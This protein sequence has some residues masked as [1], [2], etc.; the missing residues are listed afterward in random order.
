MTYG[1]PGDVNEDELVDMLDIISV[2]EWY[3]GGPIE[4]N[5]ANGEVTGEGIVDMLDIIRLMR[6]YCGTDEPLYDYAEEV[7]E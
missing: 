6:W 5:I 4:L 3:C 2:M 1:T 7:V